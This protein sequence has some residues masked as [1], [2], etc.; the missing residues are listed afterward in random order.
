MN[1]AEDFDIIKEKGAYIMADTL[2]KFK[3]G[4]LDD[5]MTK[6][7]VDGTEYPNVPLDSGSVYFAV[8]TD[9]DDGRIVYDYALART[10]LSEWNAST[11]YA[12]D[13][14]VAYNGKYYKSFVANNVGHAPY[15]EAT[16]Y[17]YWREIATRIV[18]GSNIGITV[19]ESVETLFITSPI[20]NGDGV[21]Y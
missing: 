10:G 1:L 19:D 20:T 11:S 7:T 5:L 6:K 14:E 15:G 17:N 9:N 4:S 3:T 18:M 2:V 12:K 8:D 16:S 21:S 13:A